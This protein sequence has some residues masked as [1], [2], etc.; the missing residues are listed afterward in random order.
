MSGDFIT[1]EASAL[2]TEFLEEAGSIPSALKGIAV[3][4]DEK[5]QRQKTWPGVSL[6]DLYWRGMKE[7]VPLCEMS[8]MMDICMDQ[9]KN[10]KTL[11]QILL[12][13]L[14]SQQRFKR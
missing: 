11:R 4:E 12:Y 14:Q 9:W 10:Q 1:C 3:K 7:K 8:S 2:K 5:K 13:L 6:K